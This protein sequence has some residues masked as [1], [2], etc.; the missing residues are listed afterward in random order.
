MKKTTITRRKFLGTSA[1]LTTGLSTF[2]TT[3]ISAPSIISSN[4]TLNSR[5]N[6]VQIGCI[7]YSFRSMP[8][9]SAEATLQYVLDAG[10]NAVEL[11]GGPA[12]SFAGAP[13]NEVD[14]RAFYRLRRKKGS[15]KELTDGEAKQ[16]AE[17]EAESKMFNKQMADWRASVPMKKFAKLKKM[18]QDAGVH[19]YAFKPRA[20]G[21]N[22]T[23]N[24]MEYGFKAAKALG[25]SHVTL[26]HPSD[27][28]HTQ[29]LGDLAHKH[30]IHVAYH[31]HLQ[32]TPT[33]WDTALE[34][35]RYNAMN[36]DLGH[37]VAAG[38]PSPLDLL[39]T[40]HTHILSMHVK[41]RQN[42]KNGKSNMPF[43]EGDTPIVEVLQLMRDQKYSFP[44]TIELEYKI[45]KDSDAVKE[46]RKCLAYCREA[47][48][49]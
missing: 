27:D 19:I 46:V 14:F 28:A 7:T 44:A 41:D 34:Q 13:K 45:P 12:E 8:D 29:K 17:L 37:Y 31:G 30:D 4:R 6:G 2:G 33:L 48:Q 35:S 38:N 10:I 1:I 25:A 42:A 22:N 47:L 26:E 40:K 49:G 9:Q 20:F 16:F 5:I 18:Y 43:G 15:G 36:L 32:Q 21:K 39:R 11:M 23:L 24:D 3:A